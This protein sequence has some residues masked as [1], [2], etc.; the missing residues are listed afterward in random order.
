MTMI[1]RPMGVSMSDRADV[2]VVLIAIPAVV[3]AMGV[4]VPPVRALTLR[5]VMAVKAVL[6]FSAVRIVFVGMLPSAVVTVVTVATSA[7]AGV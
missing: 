1:V 2:P 4:L 5:M 3:E 6:G 7:A